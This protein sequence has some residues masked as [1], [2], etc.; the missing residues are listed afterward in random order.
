MLPFLREETT[1]Q[2]DCLLLLVPLVQIV[3]VSCPPIEEHWA[4]LYG[5]FVSVAGP[6]KQGPDLQVLFFWA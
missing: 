4:A 3:A 1:G 6:A 2:P 5:A